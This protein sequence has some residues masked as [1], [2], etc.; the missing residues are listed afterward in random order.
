MATTDKIKVDAKPAIE[1]H[2]QRWL[3]II[4]IDYSK[5]LGG[6]EE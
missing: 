1:R 2:R 6:E 3:M 4:P 5:M